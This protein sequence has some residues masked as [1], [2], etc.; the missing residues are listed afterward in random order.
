MFRFQVRLFFGFP[1]GFVQLLLALSLLPSP[2]VSA[3]E[4]YQLFESGQVRPLA[5]S[6]DQ[7]KL[8]AVN[9]PDGHLEL[10][11][12]GVT[13]LL[14][15]AGSVPVG[16][17]PVSVA[18]RT[19]DEVWVVNHVS[20]SVSVVALSPSPRVVRTLL[21]GDEPSDLVFAGP[22]G[23]W[24]FV[25]T[26]HRGQ[27]SPNGGRGNRTSPDAADQSQF[28]TPGV[29]RADVW[30]FDTTALGAEL[31]GTPATVLS[32]FSDKPRALA[33]SPDG[34]TV[35]AAAFHS[36]NRSTIVN[37]GLVCDTSSGRMASNTLQPS[38]SINGVTSPG[39]SPTPHRNQAGQNRPETGLILQFDRPGAPV[40]Q[41][42]DELHRS[43]NAVVKLDLPDR[44]VF[45][46]DASVVPPVAVDGSAACADGAG[47]WARVGTILFNMAVNPVSGRST[48][49]TARRRI[50]CASRERAS[51]RPV[52]PARPAPVTPRACAGIWPGR[53]SRCSMARASCHA[54]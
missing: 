45:E 27:H 50:R 41:W 48:S 38:C 3:Q 37:E 33:V 32:L 6:A 49:A 54:T 11:D 7:T 18:V 47:C 13:G 16:V 30:V 46:I 28:D 20:D 34:Q 35:Y 44:D 26:A 21:V 25:T 36:G 52:P 22:G 14:T 17:E 40:G 23:R 19:P 29:P 42:S 15:R 43:W 24:A 1:N 12:I 9:T 39:G 53:G 10:F 8:F 51:T 4:G 31:G 2:G 5:A